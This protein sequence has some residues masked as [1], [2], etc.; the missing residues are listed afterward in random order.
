MIRR[1]KNIEGVKTPI[2]SLSKLSK[3]DLINLLTIKENDL[4]SRD[5]DI[6]NLL[7]LLDDK[8]KRINIQQ[9]KY[10]ALSKINDNLTIRISKLI[11]ESKWKKISSLFK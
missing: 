6:K 11:N 4:N 2:S 8:N 5:Y 3:E 7:E 10:M 9:D 1:N